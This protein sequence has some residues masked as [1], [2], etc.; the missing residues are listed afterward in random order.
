MAFRRNKE[1][2][3]DISGTG[4][5]FLRENIFFDYSEVQIITILLDRI[6]EC[7]G[8]ENQ[9]M[10]AKRAIINCQRI[11]LTVDDK[12]SKPFTSLKIR[13]YFVNGKAK[14]ENNKN[15]K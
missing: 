15:I 7:I 4:L 13:K 2:I 6:L 14:F 11:D 8:Y 10:V 1:I 12:N 9:T 5:Q 3:L